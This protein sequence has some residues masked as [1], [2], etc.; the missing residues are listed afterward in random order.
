MRATP[1]FTS[2]GKG[3]GSTPLSTTRECRARSAHTMQTLYAGNYLNF[4]SWL[5]HNRNFYAS[6]ALRMWRI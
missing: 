6:C 5:F 1:L 3:T 2:R 4:T